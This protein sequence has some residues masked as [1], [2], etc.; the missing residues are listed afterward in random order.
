M[1]VTFFASRPSQCV[2][3]AVSCGVYPAEASFRSPVQPSADLA[4]QAHRDLIAASPALADD[5]ECHTQP[6]VVQV[7]DTDSD[8]TLNVSNANARLILDTLGLPFD[9]CSLSGSA[10][11]EQ[12]LG[13]VLLAH[14]LAPAELGVPSY[15]EVVPGGARMIFVGRPEGYLQS[16]LDELH[17][18]GVFARDHGVGVSWS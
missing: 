4:L 8:P 5:C 14:G 3:F 1:S 12:F 15:E 17:A 18:V 10:L 11:S 16:R 7:R 13:A 2:G 9:E 6:Y